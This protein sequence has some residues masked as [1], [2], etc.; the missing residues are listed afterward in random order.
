MYFY[1]GMNYRSLVGV[2]ISIPLRNQVIFL[3]S[4]SAFL[5]CS[6]HTFPLVFSSKI[7][8]FNCEK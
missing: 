5:K 8:L 2:V 6:A 4:L 1:P 3:V 7:I